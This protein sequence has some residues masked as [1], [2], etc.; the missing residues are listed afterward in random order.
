MFKS[1]LKHAI[2]LQLALGS[3]AAFAT[4]YTFTQ[5]TSNGSPSVESQLIADVTQSGS[6]VLFTFTNTSVIAS[7]IT[8]VYFDYGS[9]SFFANGNAGISNNILGLAGESSGVNFSDGARP[10]NL[11]SGNTIGFSSDAAGD[12][13][14][15]S[16]KN[17]VN[18]SSEFVAFLGTT[19]TGITFGDVIAGLDTGAFRLGLHVQ[20]INYGTDDND[21][22]DGTSE[23]FV[24]NPRAVPLP[25]AGWLFGSALVGL[26]GLHR[27]KL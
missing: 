14:R 6:N 15:P 9:T 17:G 1:I 19:L 24:N 10:H 3:A 5:F 16:S 25:A 27:R 23:S 22:D 8:D 13:N 4:T 7:S 20:K 18:T 2:V 12:S 21:D 26:M 11:P